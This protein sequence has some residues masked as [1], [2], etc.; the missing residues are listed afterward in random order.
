MKTEAERTAS[1]SMILQKSNVLSV[2]QIDF[3]KLFESGTGEVVSHTKSLAC[4]DV[5]ISRSVKLANGHAI[6]SRSTCFAI[7]CK[8]SRFSETVNRSSSSTS[9]ARVMAVTLEIEAMDMV[10][11]EEAMDCMV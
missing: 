7:C 6:Q 9:N 5:P 2:V 11:G 1:A 10:R 8:I 3:V 4:Q